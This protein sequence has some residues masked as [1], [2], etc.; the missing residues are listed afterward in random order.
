MSIEWTIISAMLDGKERKRRK[1]FRF[2]QK[3]I[4]DTKTEKFS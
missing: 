4:E 2:I 3:L 1:R